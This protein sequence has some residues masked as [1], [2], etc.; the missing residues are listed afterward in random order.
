MPQ[1]HLDENNAVSMEGPDIVGYR[2]QLKTKGPGPLFI[3][4]GYLI[5]ENAAGCR[6]R[7]HGSPD[8]VT[9]GCPESFCQFL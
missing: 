5:T 8:L 6:C 1:S 7:V 3:Y 2:Q 4:S 9:L